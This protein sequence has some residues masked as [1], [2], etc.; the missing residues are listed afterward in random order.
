MKSLEINGKLREITGKKEAKKLRTLEMVPCVIYGNDETIHFSAPFSEFRALV[1]TP[2]VYVAK[3]LID[4]KEY[5]TILQDMQWHPVEEKLLH[6]DFLMISD[7]KPVKLELPV[8]ITGSAKGI[9]AGGKLKVNVRKMKVKGI[10]KDMPD[11]ILV[12]VS[13]LDVGQSFKVGDIKIEGLEILAP[14][15]NVIATV[16]VTRATKTAATG[17]ESK[18]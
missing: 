16:A 2:D 12:D 8:N 5:E 4:G 10:V 14:K 9:K 15:T 17:K 3:L 1:Y 7:K 18:K 13:D 11:A 6:A